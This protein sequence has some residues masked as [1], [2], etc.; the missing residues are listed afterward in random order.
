MSNT[1]G[2][3]HCYRRLCTYYFLISQT[4]ILIL[5]TL[6]AP[7]VL[8]SITPTRPLAGD[9]TLVSSNALFE[10][11]FFT[12]ENSGRWYVGIWYKD[13]E[14]KTVV[15]VAN[16]NTPLTNATGRGVLRIGEDGGI[17]LVDGGGNSIWSSET[18]TRPGPGN[19]VAELLDSGNFVLRRENDRSEEKYL[20]QSF[21]HPT[22]TLLPGM[23]LGWDSKTGLNRY[24]SSWKTATDPAEGDFSFKLDTNGLPEAFLRKKN[25]VIYGSG[26]WNGIRF[27]GVPEMNPTAIITFLFVTTK[28]ENYYT[29]ELHNQ[30]IFSKL[31]VSHGG[32]L[33]RYM[34]I[35]T[36]KIWNKFWYAPAD[37]CDYYKECGPY[38]ICD[39]SISPVCECL[40]GFGPR[41][42]QA[43]DLRDGRDGCVRVHDLD[44]ENDGFLAL[45][46]MK[47]PE[48]SGAFV[49][50]GMSFDECTAMCKR[51][52]SCAAY[53]SSN[54]TGDGSGCVMWT[55]ELLD[56]RRY[57]AA[58]GGQVLYVR[59]AASD[60]VA[61][62]G[63]IA[64]TGNHSSSKTK[65][66]VLA[67]GIILGIAIALL[68]F[69]ALFLI[70][71]RKSQSAMR[72]TDHRGL[73]SERGH[74]DLVMNAPVIP[75]K[76]DHSGE[77]AAEESF[78]LPVFDFST[79]VVA[80]DSFADANKLGQGGFGCVY[81]GIIDGD[82][83]EI[84]VKRLSKNSGQ[85]VEE[86][87]NELRLIARLQHRNLVR[88]LGCCVDMDEKMLIY[89]YME[90]K[91]LDSVIF[92]RTKSVLLN[93]QKRFNIIRGIAR[94]LLYLH[95]DSRFRIIHRDLKASNIL[96]DKEMN[97]K[98]SDFGM[99]RIFGGDETE[100]NNTK[101]VVGTYGYM[102]PEYA[103]D[104]LFSVK[105]D[106]FSFGVL[107]LEIVSG[108]KNRGFYNQN[109]QQNLLGH[110]WGLWREGRGSELLDPAVGESFSPSE[111]MRCIQVGLVC[112]QEQAEDRPNMATV[113]LML[114]SESTTLPQPK[115][116]GFCLGIRRRA[117]IDSSVT[118]YDET[119]SVNHVTVT[120]LDGR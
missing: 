120:I 102:S 67:C 19:T 26:A 92:N 9:Q 61:V 103:M 97:P 68:G 21:D 23:K 113:L 44:C 101:R 104:G 28:S 17:Y 105:S 14:E 91:S 50:A 3:R 88:L 76:R 109:N 63:G 5:P 65:R 81:K 98:I 6:T 79:I 30:T 75:S 69:S 47:L 15:W 93:W 41:N 94:G 115:H 16:R 108:K 2:H 57:T 107:V 62:Q 83:Q 99:A 53:A 37:Q 38:G 78:E 8:D 73:S 34:W 70:K 27:S 85:G 54:I 45:N 110:A 84:A 77:T 43:W 58:E 96:L 64:A 59:A 111:V 1:A 39:T 40:V 4:L 11:G 89:E 100:A 118:N 31:Q 32:Y 74:Q 80:T 87:K 82:D 22:D 51:N 35:P 52:C 36:S 10:L 106:V 60:V 29:F 12:P 13:I 42:K 46:Y 49:D 119:H 71:R 20:W 72:Y 18:P 33:E 25:D 95:Q 48:S 86:F 55:T 66:I 112:V 114:S 56:M 24:I 90:N 116:P 7:L 117:D